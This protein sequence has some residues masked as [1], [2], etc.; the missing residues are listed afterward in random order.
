M[1]VNSDFWST[2]YIERQFL[3]VFV[4][5]LFVVFYLFVSNGVAQDESLEELR[6]IYPK[7]DS[8]LG[9]ELQEGEIDSALAIAQIISGTLLKN[10][11]PGQVKRD[12]HTKAHG[13]VQAK[14]SVEEFLEEGLAKGVFIPGKTYDA[15]IRYSNGKADPFRADIEKDSRGM[16]IKLLGVDGDTLLERDASARTQDFVMLN[17]P[18]FFLDDPQDYL[19]LMQLFTSENKIKKKLA[20]LLM[21]FSVGLKSTK[22]AAQLS[23][24][25]V[26]NPL[27]VR[28]W[29]SV[30]YQLGSGDERIAVKFSA[31][32]CNKP[33]E[34][35][36]EEP[37]NDFLRHEMKETLSAGSACME[38]LVQ[39][40]TSKT[41][42][43]EDS[44]TEWLEE[45]AP[46]YKVATITIP[47]QIFDTPEQNKFCENLSFTPWHALA[48]HRP[49]GSVNR[50]RKVIYA[51]ISRT[52]REANGVAN[53]EP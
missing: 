27:T 4:I 38:F 20:P 24:A 13:C 15:W 44:R 40:R 1:N 28:Y 46:F 51:H 21:P 8:F 37:H 36:P 29:S 19:S 5:T 25:Q 50:L 3:V 12:A 23:K 39:P 53:V 52:R 22:L 17:S 7:V 31:R 42:S 26:S 6:N 14:F 48:E 33:D 35:L 9:E 30:P 16:A 45:R 10:Y 43:V 32:P 41:M 49:L 34:E 11:P 2:N 47:E 18:I